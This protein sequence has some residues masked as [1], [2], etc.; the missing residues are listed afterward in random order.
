[1][2]TFYNENRIEPQEWEQL[3]KNVA[4]LT[5]ELASLRG[6][7][8][9]GSFITRIR[10]EQIYRDRKV[11][12]DT[13]LAAAGKITYRVPSVDIPQD[14]KTLLAEVSDKFRS[15]IRRPLVT[16]KRARHLLWYSLAVVIVSLFLSLYCLYEL[17]FS[18]FAYAKRAY[19]VYAEQGHK[20]PALIY[21][22]IVHDW[23]DKM[24]RKEIKLDVK[25][26]EATVKRLKKEAKATSD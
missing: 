6:I 24:I 10:N 23:D 26:R 16:E 12:T 7:L 5:N 1:M 3:N 15:I 19:I 13:M 21:D 4:E 25:H 9:E 22:D 8:N 20:D 17:R 11:I 14:S 2:E 18:K